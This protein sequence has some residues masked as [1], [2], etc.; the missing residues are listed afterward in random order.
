MPTVGTNKCSRPDGVALAQWDALTSSHT[1]KTYNPPTP[2][3]HPHPL[4]VLKRLFMFRSLFETVPRR[5]KKNNNSFRTFLFFQYVSLFLQSCRDV[6]VWLRAACSAWSLALSAAS[7]VR[8]APGEKHSGARNTWRTKRGE[9]LKKAGGAEDPA[10][11]RPC[12]VPVGA[13]SEVLLGGC[14]R[15]MLVNC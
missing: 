11:T 12:T 2:P 15:K 13:A 7:R 5:R 8:Q 10:K 1:S 14:F 9:T 4:F 3:T 6:S